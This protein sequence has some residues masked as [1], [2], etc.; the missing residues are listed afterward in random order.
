M[1]GTSPGPLG[2]LGDL[3]RKPGD[4]RPGAKSAKPNPLG[5]DKKAAAK[6]VANVIVLFQPPN[7][8]EEIPAANQKVYID[9]DADKPDVMTQLQTDSAGRIRRGPGTSATPVWLDPSRTFHV[10]VSAKD[11]ATAPSP[12]Q[13]VAVQ[14]KSGKIVT[15]PHIAV[16][17]T[18]DGTTPIGGLACIL[19]V[20]AN[21]AK[22]ASSAQG[23]VVSADRS[24]GAVTIKAA[25]KLIKFPA[26]R[27]S[28]AELDITPS[29]PD[30]LVRGSKARIFV[31]TVNQVPGTIG[32]KATEWSYDISHKNPGSSSSSTATIKRSAKEDP[33]SFDK[34]WEGILC[35]SGTARM[36]FVT[37][38]T[39]RDSGDAAVNTTVTALDPVEAKLEIT[40][41]SRS[42]FQATLLEENEQSLTRA[43]NGRFENLGQHDWNFRPPKKGSA[44]DLV[45]PIGT[46][47]NRGCRFISAFGGTFVSTP[48]INTQLTDA[49]S[50]FSQTQDKAYLTMVNN[51]VLNPA[52]VIPRNLYDIVPSGA[53]E[54]GTNIKIP[55]KAAM[56]TALGFPADASLKFTGHCAT[57]AAILSSTR[58]HEFGDAERSHKANCLKALR[59]LDPWGVAEALVLLPGQSLNDLS[60][61]IM[62]RIKLVLKAANSDDPPQGI[63]H[64]VIDEAATRKAQDLVFAAGEQVPDIIGPVWD[65]TVNALVTNK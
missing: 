32:F 34:D 13:G 59:A 5:L 62:K 16:K 61:L 50:K 60:T 49:N 4:T 46:G 30:P 39:M 9:L 47:P 29:P 31:S 57:Q 35:A 42:S 41:S 54:S 15:A 52:K 20:A 27:T 36:K 55:D 45:P 64:K 24:P 37:G 38:R 33:A 40:V 3:A 21:E 8:T 48:R 58:Q 10:V 19:S 53:G 43:I 25:A 63:D 22:I 7:S 44:L 28:I 11:L 12:A 26:D 51:K 14:V 2:I 1:A 17:I 65:P 23:F 56:L 6:L 18:T